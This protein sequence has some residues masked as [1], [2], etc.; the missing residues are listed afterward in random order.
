MTFTLTKERRQLVA[1][2]LERE[3]WEICNWY[4]KEGPRTDMSITYEQ[5]AK[6]LGVPVRVVAMVDQY[7]DE[8]AEVTDIIGDDLI[9]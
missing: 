1:E 9:K 4:M 8:V 6:S 5:R 2:L 3:F 7:L